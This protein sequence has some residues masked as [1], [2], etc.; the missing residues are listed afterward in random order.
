MILGI[1][2]TVAFPTLV[3]VAAAIVLGRRRAVSA[4]EYDSDSV[5]FVGGVLNALFTVVLAFYV[6]FAWQ[7]GDDIDSSSGAEADALVDAFWQAEQL[8]EPERTQLQTLV[9]SYTSR[10]VDSEWELL[11]RGEV[12]PKAAQIIEQMRAGFAAL[13]TDAG[14]VE[15]AREQ[16]LLDVRQ[17]DENHRARVADIVEGDSFNV[18]LLG[19]TIFGAVVMLGFPLLAGLGP[20]P[21]NVVAMGLLAITLGSTIFLSIQLLHPLEGMFAADPDVFIEVLDRMPA[22][23]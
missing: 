12:D 13:P 22:P 5:S 2:L 6:V 9:R 4:G 14:R 7:I 11:A 15:A 3:V 17:I 20:R 18:T 21:A 10:V 1:V 8:A 19:A 23:T 16:G